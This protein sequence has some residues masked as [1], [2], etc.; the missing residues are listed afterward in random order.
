MTRKKFIKL[1]TTVT[2]GIIMMLNIFYTVDAEE[3]YDECQNIIKK[4]EE[5]VNNKQLEEY[6]SLFD[7]ETQNWM[8]EQKEDSNFFIGEF[9]DIL[10]IKE[11]S[12]ET[13]KKAAFIEDNEFHDLQTK[14]YYVQVDCDTTNVNNENIKP[15][16]GY[17]PYV[18]VLVLENSQWKIGRVSI[19]DVSQIISSGEGLENDIEEETAMKESLSMARAKLSVPSTICIKMTKKQNTDYWGKTYVNVNFKNYI[20]NVVPNEFTVSY[21]G[22]YLKAGTMVVKM[23]GWYYTIHKKYP[24]SPGGCDLQDTSVDQNYL[25]GSYS[26][27]G[28]YKSTMDDAYSEISTKALVNKSGNIFLTQYISG[29]TDSKTGK[30]GAKTALSLSQSGNKYLKI[31]QNAYNNSTNADK[32]TV[33][34]VE[35]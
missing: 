2:L 14:V 13:G 17:I 25:A 9:I 31:L 35:H 22:E 7:S 32:E 16:D 1:V 5:Y 26:N 10:E 28:K 19:A 4:Y 8:N 29:D 21:G 23:F 27:L 15:L 30:L 33:K 3:T 18:F 24:N 34:I 20:L 6:I 12:I 11:L